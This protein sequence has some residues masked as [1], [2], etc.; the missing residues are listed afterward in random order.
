MRIASPRADSLVYPEDDDKK[1]SIKDNVDSLFGEEDKHDDDRSDGKPEL[2][3]VLSDDSDGVEVEDEE[4]LAKKGKAKSG[5]ADA[6]TDVV[7]LRVDTPDGNSVRQEV[8]F[9]EEWEDILEIIYSCMRC[10]DIPVKLPLSY[11]LANWTAKTLSSL[12]TDRADWQGCISTTEQYMRSLNAA[13]KKKNGNT[14]NTALISSSSRGS[15]SSKGKTWEEPLLDLLGNEGNENENGNEPID[16]VGGSLSLMEQEQ[17]WGER[18]HATYTQCQACGPKVMCKIDNDRNHRHVKHAHA[19]A[20]VNTLALRTRGVTLKTPLKSDLFS[21]WHKSLHKPLSKAIPS[22]FPPY[23]LL[24]PAPS[25]GVNS[26]LLAATVALVAKALNKE[27]PAK[28]GGSCSI[29]DGDLEYLL[30]SSFIA[31][32]HTKQPQRNLDLYADVFKHQDLY[33][34]DELVDMSIT[35]LTA[36]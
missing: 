16:D 23:I 27:S 29:D 5:K 3:D 22:S 19:N 9:Y 11:R 25:D 14:R 4:P 34:I 2:V 32:L 12:L 30:I 17:Q 31:A 18:L 15:W 7:V 10:E 1:G 6:I 24:Q 26:T 35:D 13:W 8:P 20:W 33:N 36:V 28:S 21:P